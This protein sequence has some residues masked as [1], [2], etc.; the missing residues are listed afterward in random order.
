M[1][2]N[3]YMAKFRRIMMSDYERDFDKFDDDERDF[4][5][6]KDDN[7]CMSTI[8]IKCDLEVE[9]GSKN[10]IIYVSPDNL[11]F[12]TANAIC[13]SSGDTIEIEFC[14]SNTKC[15]RGETFIV[16]RLGFYKIVDS[17]IIFIP[18][19]KSSKHSDWCFPTDILHFKAKSK[20]GEEIKFVVVFTLA[21][22]KCAD[23]KCRC[24]K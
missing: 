8:K 19:H 6:S 17:G 24:C 1:Y 11:Q 18:K 23:H 13:C 10:K 21:K 20:C 5:K 14:G 2:I 15:I 7:C 4:D 9:I 12:F 22:S 16:G 3:I